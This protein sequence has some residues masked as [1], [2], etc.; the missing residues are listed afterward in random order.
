MA[1]SYRVV[2]LLC[3]MGYEINEEDL[4]KS[5]LFNRRVLRV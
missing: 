3:L 1:K 5:A 4:I 2:R